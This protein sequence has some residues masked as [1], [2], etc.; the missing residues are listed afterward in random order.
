MQGRRPSRPQRHACAVALP[1]PWPPQPHR[2][3]GAMPVQ[4]EHPRRCRAAGMLFC[5]FRAAAGLFQ[6]S[7]MATARRTI[8]QKR[9][10][11]RTPPLTLFPAPGRGA[12]AAGKE[13]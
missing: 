9:A 12:P 7:R 8:L 6:F 2:Y 10:E 3:P 5:F 11:A 13:M 1:A 4:K